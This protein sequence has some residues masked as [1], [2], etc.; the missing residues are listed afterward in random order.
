MT[1]HAHPHAVGDAP[2]IGHG[3]APAMAGVGELGELVEVASW[4]GWAR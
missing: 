1:G 2:V 3:Q 4:P